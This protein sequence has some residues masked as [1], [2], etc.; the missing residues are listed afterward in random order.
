MEGPLNSQP[1]ALRLAVILAAG[2][3][4][5]D[6]SGKANSGIISN[7]RASSGRRATGNADALQSGAVAA[8]QLPSL[9]SGMNPWT[10]GS[11]I[12][13]LLLVLPIGVAAAWLFRRN[14]LSGNRHQ[15]RR[16]FLLPDVTPPEAPLGREK[17]HND[18]SREVASHEERV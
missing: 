3:S 8:L 6:G 9:D 10:S 5:T 12:T 14:P 7:V 2:V 16:P 15:P 17:D 18:Y 1:I 4:S 13:A 11:P